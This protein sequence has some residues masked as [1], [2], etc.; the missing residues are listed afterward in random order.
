M[1][2]NELNTMLICIKNNKTEIEN[3][4]QSI[5]N[6][7][8]T[9]SDIYSDIY[10]DIYSDNRNNL[11]TLNFQ[12]KLIKL[13]HE[14]NNIIF[15]TFLN[16]IYGDYYKLY[17]DM[18]TYINNYIKDISTS[19][20]IQFPKYKDLETLKEYNFEFIESLHSYILLFLN[21]FLKFSLKENNTINDLLK[22]DNNGININNFINEKKFFLNLTNHKFNLYYENLKGYLLVQKKFLKRIYIKLKL[23]H[24]QLSTDINLEISISD[25]DESSTINLDNLEISSEEE[26]IEKEVEEES[27]EEELIEEEEEPIKTERNSLY[28]LGPISLSIITGLILLNYYGKKNDDTTFIDPFFCFNFY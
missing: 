4:L 25:Q 19:T 23:M 24:K 10:G 11:D 16:R 9:L 5:T 21:E 27:I 6:T 12:I 28:Y 15:K 8:N 3:I 2:F 22:K 14:N 18:T 13:E 26:S 7:I 1:D 20:D 17:K